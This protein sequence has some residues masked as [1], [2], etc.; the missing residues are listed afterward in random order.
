[1][2]NML[3]HEDISKINEIKTFFTDSWL[4]PGVLSD[5]FNKTLSEVS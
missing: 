3:Q 2:Q 5:K 4:L 1:M